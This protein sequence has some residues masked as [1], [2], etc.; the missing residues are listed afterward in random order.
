MTEVRLVEIG[1][2]VL[3]VCGSKVN[4]AKRNK[5]KQSYK[6]TITFSIDGTED[7]RLKRKGLQELFINTTL[8]IV[9]ST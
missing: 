4:T 6:N 1:A 8:E 3:M 7:E 9:I 2:N 5:L